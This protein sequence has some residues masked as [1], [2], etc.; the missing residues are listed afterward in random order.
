VALST[1]DLE[2]EALS[3]V[4]LPLTKKTVLKRVKLKGEPQP[5][6]LVSEL[7]FLHSKF[8]QIVKQNSSVTIN[9]LKKK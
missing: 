2:L 4:R 1:C 6:E 5:H 8:E 9:L 3:R 7:K